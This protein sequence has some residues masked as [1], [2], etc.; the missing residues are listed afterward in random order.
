MR[1]CIRRHGKRTVPKSADE[2]ACQWAGGYGQV[3]ALVAAKRER[4]EREARLK[5]AK[6]LCDD[7]I[8]GIR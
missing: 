6:D 3:Q 1:S 4:K 8:D 5:E 7:V 2:R